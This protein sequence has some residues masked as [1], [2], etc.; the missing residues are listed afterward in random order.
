MTFTVI[1]PCHNAE[2]WVAE[3]LRSAR[4]QTRPPDQIIVVNDASTDASADAVRNSGVDV[5]LIEAD[6]RNAAAARNLALPRATGDWI[7][8]LDADDAWKPHHLEQ[9]AALI[10]QGNDVGLT[11]QDDY[12][13]MDGSTRPAVN[14]WPIDAPAAG[15]TPE[16]FIECW[17]Q[18]LKFSMITTLVRRDRLEAIGGFD[19]SQRRRHDFDMWL[20]LIR[21]HTWAYNPRSTAVYRVTP[22][23]IGRTNWADSEYFALRGLAKNLDA[24]PGLRPFVSAAARRAVA[25]AITDGDASDRRRALELAWPHLRARD[26]AVFTLARLAPPAFRAAHRAKRRRQYRKGRVRWSPN[27]APST[28]SGQP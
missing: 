11:G 20:R 6:V 27:V 4:D 13:Y 9:A 2:A 21:D 25:S 19:E 14:A 16:R 5:E 18:H 17:R 12:L 8:F 7:A 3:A 22:G 15:L 23:S 28:A 24:Y 26:R 10:E 1:M